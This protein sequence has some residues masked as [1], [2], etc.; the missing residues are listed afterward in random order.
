MSTMSLFKI[1]H[2]KCSGNYML[3]TKN[4]TLD[5]LKKNHI[6]LKQ[7]YFLYQKCPVVEEIRYIYKQHDIYAYY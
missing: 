7:V 1:H 3:E 2:L 6:N 4:T 5:R